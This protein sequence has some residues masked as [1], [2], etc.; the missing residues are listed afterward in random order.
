MSIVRAR[1]CFSALVFALGA[2]FMM[3]LHAADYRPGEVLVKFRDGASVLG[4]NQ[5]LAARPGHVPVTAEVSR[6]GIRP[7]ETVEQVVLELQALPEVEFAEPNYVRRIQRAPDDPEFGVQWALRNTGQVVN[8]GPPLGAQ[9]GNAGADIGAT[10]AWDTTI[11]SRNVVV[12]VIDTGIDLNHPELAGNLWAR[13]NGVRGRDFV[14]GDSDPR[15]THG[16]GTSIAGVIGARTDNGRGMAGTA[17]EVSLMALRVFGDDGR[18]SNDN[19]VAA[20]EYA[21]QNGARVINASFGS[22]GFSSIEYNA[23]RRAGEQGILVVAAACNEGANNDVTA[24]GNRSCYPASYDLPNIISVAATDNADTLI[25]SSNY[26]VE[27]VDL[28][29]PGIGILS[30]GLSRSNGSIPLALNTGTSIAAAFVSGAAA[31]LLARNGGLSVAELRTALL[32]NV[33]PASGLAGRVATG[34][35][36]N[37]AA[38]LA[39]VPAGPQSAGTSTPRGSS[40]G[41]GAWTVYASILL[42]LVY[43]ARRLRGGSR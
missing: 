29:A 39:S 41:G 17:W 31:L 34:G 42:L 26:G 23:L 1:H 2:C 32:D 12:A 22:E 27:T 38:A 6:I 10:E 28:G 14:D 30:L 43:G 7:G 16:H 36:L 8:L 21:R 4:V 15:D 33:D 19:I 9:P 18:G 5:V 35:R 13:S 37:V 3:P 24:G 25:F 20:I 40:G 11:G